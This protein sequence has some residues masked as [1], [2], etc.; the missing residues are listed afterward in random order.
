MQP[1]DKFTSMDH[2]EIIYLRHGD[3]HPFATKKQRVADDDATDAF[4]PRWSIE[5]KH[6]KRRRGIWHFGWT[7]RCVCCK[8]VLADFLRI[9]VVHVFVLIIS[10]FMCINIYIVYTHLCKYIERESERERESMLI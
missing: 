6:S 8:D 4:E 5:A 10:C 3:F 1:F 2:L 9:S 7:R